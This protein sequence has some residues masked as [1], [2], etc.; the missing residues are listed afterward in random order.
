MKLYFV[1]ADQG[2]SCCFAGH[3]LAGTPKA[4]IEIAKLE[5]D[6]S[7]LSGQSSKDYGWF[8]RKSNADPKAMALNLPKEDR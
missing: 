5:M 3:W 7:P 2:G 6:T 8:A 4:A 1:R